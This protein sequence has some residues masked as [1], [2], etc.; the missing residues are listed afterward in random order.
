MCI[1]VSCGRKLPKHDNLKNFVPLPVTGK[2]FLLGSN[3]I[4]LLD[5]HIASHIR[6][7]ALNS[8]TCIE[9][10]H[11]PPS[12][13]RVG[14]WELA[15]KGKEKWKLGKLVEVGNVSV[16]QTFHFSEVSERCR[17]ALWGLKF[18]PAQLHPRASRRRR[19]HSGRCNIFARQVWQLPPQ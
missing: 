14:L 10:T 7:S 4:L 16:Y 15:V 8:M 3:P 11:C 9:A 18:I 13:G 5:F 12:K 2:Y 17:A 1:H 6:V 19:S